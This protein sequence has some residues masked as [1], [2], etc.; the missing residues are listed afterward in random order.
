MNPRPL[1]LLAVLSLVL[2]SFAEDQPQL[3]PGGRSVISKDWLDGLQPSGG[4]ENLATSQRIV[5]AGQPFDSAIEVTVTGTPPNAYSLQLCIKNTAPI[6]KGDTLYGT[7]Y[8]RCEQ[9]MAGAGYLDFEFEKASP[10]WKKSIIFPVSARGEWK[11]VQVPF[12]ALADYAPGEAQ[13]N[14]RLGYPAQTVQI[15][16]AKLVDYGPGVA[17]K[18]LPAT[19]VTYA[20]HEPDATWRAEANKRID[21]YRKA[22]ITVHVA[23]AAGKPVAGVPVMIAQQRHAFAF[24]SCVVAAKLANEDPASQPYRDTVAKL[25]N[26]VVFENDMK[27]G[28][29]EAG[30]D[31]DVQPAL[32]WLEDRHILVRG[33][34]LVWPSWRFLPKSVKDL[35]DDK[36]KLKAAIEQ[37]VTETAAKYKGRVVDWDVLNEPYTNH[38]IQDLLGRDVMVD[39]F[40]LARAADP[41]AKLYLNDFGIT[42]GGGSGK[43]HQ[44]YTYDVLK[45]LID[46]KAPID[47]FGLQSHFDMSLTEPNR[48]YQ[49]LDRYAAL[50]LRLKVTEL[51][52]VV[53]DQQLQAD[54]LR[55]YMTICFSHPSMDGIL[56]W[57]FWE[58]AHWLPKAALFNADWSPRPSAKAFEDLVYHTWWTN[59]TLTTDANGNVS[60]RGFLGDY[61]ISTGGAKKTVSLD[62]NGAKVD[63]EAAK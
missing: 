38:E 50:G 20:G 62:K 26:E 43:A 6:A 56:M 45:F 16:D 42:E 34:N 29:L 13:L 36:E 39:W 44:D 33:H 4:S 12:T 40:K 46:H 55:D 25:F 49:I 9:S 53:P 2:P 23:D 59:T 22:D 47:G 17:V 27:W 58:K 3:P 8:A 10:D 32:K 11:L 41:N 37:H 19:K 28:R 63:L 30:S 52:I 60:T 1:A 18:D 48:V 54:Y 24:G 14:F 31:K 5:V 35:K 57:G 51:D 15:A 7:F 21:Q 61:E